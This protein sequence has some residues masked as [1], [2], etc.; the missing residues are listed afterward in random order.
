M[1]VGWYYCIEV[2][3]I[4]KKKLD[5]KYK[6]NVV[7]NNQCASKPMYSEPLTLSDWLEPSKSIDVKQGQVH[8]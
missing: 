4:S 7:G 1:C 8:E 3:R 5:T 6:G 2:L